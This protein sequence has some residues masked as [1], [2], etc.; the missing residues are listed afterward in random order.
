MV[1]TN[2]RK[3]ITRAENRSQ[4][5]FRRQFGKISIYDAFRRILIARGAAVCVNLFTDQ[6][7]NRPH[8]GQTNLRFTRFGEFAA[9]I[10]A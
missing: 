10:E 1:S 9:K 3:R 6:I 2:S 5:T 8:K 4:G 7:S